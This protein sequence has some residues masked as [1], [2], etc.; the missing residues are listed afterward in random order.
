MRR[1]LSLDPFSSSIRTPF[2]PW[3]AGD[4]SLTKLTHCLASWSPSTLKRLLSSFRAMRASSRPRSPYSM[5]LNL[6][7]EK[8]LEELRS[9][10]SIITRVGI[11][12]HVIE[13][14]LVVFKCLEVCCWL[15]F[16]YSLLW[17][18]L[19][20]SVIFTKPKLSNQF[21][22]QSQQILSLLLSL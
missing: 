2:A 13:S 4:S 9:L 1:I 16:R 21:R 19:C 15:K 18:L 22:P 7:R 14:R 8:T 5:L 6:N 10:S 20:L 11:M 17:V 3:F 12:C